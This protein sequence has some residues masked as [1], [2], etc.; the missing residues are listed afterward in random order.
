MSQK[1][2]IVGAP[3]SGTNMLRDILCSF[4]GIS[5]WPCDEINYIW[6][7]GNPSYP[8]DEL[9][10]SLAKKNIKQYISKQ[11]DWVQNNYDAKIIIEKTCA[12]SLR[13]SYVDKIIPDAKYI[14][15]VRD[16]IDVVESAKKRWSAKINLSYVVKK[17]RFV[18]KQSIPYYTMRYFKSLIYKLFSKDDRLQFWGPIYNNMEQEIKN[19][20]LVEV[21]AYQWKKCVDSS[22][23]TISLMPNKKFHR[24]K[25]E[26]FVT[27][28]EKE[29]NNILNFLDISYPK[30]VIQKSIKNVVRRNIGKGRKV[31]SS[32]EVSS[33]TKIFKDTMKRHMYD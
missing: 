25:Y 2:V 15:I 21:C 20:S 19:I 24:I 13:L 5:S 1:V 28:P 4:D 23:M 9:P 22:D 31:L 17:A 33:I 29:L 27:E 32:S 3:R 18:P 6:R 26:D 12:N 14:Y 10:A 7:Y 16:G 11:F 8:S 30:E